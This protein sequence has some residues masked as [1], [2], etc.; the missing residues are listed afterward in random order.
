MALIS[1]PEC[2]REI[3][4]NAATCPVCGYHLQ[5]V[6]PEHGRAMNTSD[7][8]GWWKLGLSIAGRIAI[9]VSVAVLGWEWDMSY[10]AV[11]GGITIAG[12]SIPAWYKTKI[13]RLRGVGGG[14]DKIERLENRLA[15][16]ENRHQMDMADIDQ[17][18]REQIAEL[19][20]RIEFTERLVA[21]KREQI[22]SGK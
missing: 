9:G 2:G 1:C 3:S 4:N 17:V 21:S 5:L 7:R 18:H 16:L 8:S 15:E 14:A 20:E 6:V 22:G 19:E 12:S 13:D 11:F 10:P